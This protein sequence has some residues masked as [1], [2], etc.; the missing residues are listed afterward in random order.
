MI[1]ES[2]LISE[3]HQCLLFVFIDEQF[4][5]QAIQ[6]LDEEVTASYF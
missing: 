3:I 6:Q 2:I 1:K 4:S 5:T